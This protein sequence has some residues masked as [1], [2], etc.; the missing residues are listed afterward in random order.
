MREHHA[1]PV[2]HDR[3]VLAVGQSGYGQVFG[4]ELVG[5]GP[6]QKAPDFA[7]PDAVCGHPTVHQW[8]QAGAER[9]SVAAEVEAE[10]TRYS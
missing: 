5:C 3:P 2:T 7:L 1:V 4:S 6:R 9:A 10:L 8:L